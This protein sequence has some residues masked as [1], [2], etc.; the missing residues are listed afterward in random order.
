[1]REGSKYCLAFNC[2]FALKENLLKS[3]LASF[4]CLKDRAALFLAVS[5]VDPQWDLIEKQE[6]V[7]CQISINCTH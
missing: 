5:L 1:M 2:S 7:L 4:L 3:Y 6:P